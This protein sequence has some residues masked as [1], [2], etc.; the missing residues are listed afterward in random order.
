[1][2]SLCATGI[3][4]PRCVDRLPSHISKTMVSTGR[5]DGFISQDNAG[6]LPHSTSLSL[7]IGEPTYRT[8]L[9]GGHEQFRADG[10]E[11]R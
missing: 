2:L 4:R 7:L 10:N 5:G 9:G 1:M 6:S 3:E 11:G 8:Q